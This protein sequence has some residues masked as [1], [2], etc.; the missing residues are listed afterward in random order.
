MFITLCCWVLFCYLVGK[1]AEKRGK[2]FWTYAVISGIVSPLLGFII[3][4]ITCGKQTN[5]TASAAQHFSNSYPS[6]QQ[7]FVLP[8]E[9]S[10][11]SVEFCPHCGSKVMSHFSN[12]PNC[13][14]SLK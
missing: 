13:G 5:T 10:E 7:H 12:C 3:A 14:A 8:E 9:K 4:L 1:Y 11:A 6:Q 2:S